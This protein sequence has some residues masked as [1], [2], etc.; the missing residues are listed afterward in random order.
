MPPEFE[1]VA[2]QVRK[3]RLE[4]KRLR[5]TVIVSAVAI[6]SVVALGSSAFLFWTLAA[7]LVI[8]LY[9]LVGSARLIADGWDFFSMRW[10]RARWQAERNKPVDDK[11]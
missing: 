3:V 8:L 11:L 6:C 4:V 9:C 5:Y 10:Q 7:G 2:R 1:E